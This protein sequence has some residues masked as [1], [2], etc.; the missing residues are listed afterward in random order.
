MNQI[1]TFVVNILEKYSSF[2]RFAIVGCINTL[3]YYL[4][5]I[6]F[7]FVG[8]PYIF[9]HSAAFGISMIGSFYLNCYYTYKVKPTWK[10]FIQ[11]PMTYVVN[12]SV[13]TLSLF[14]IVDLLHLNAFIA[15]IISMLLP[16]PFTFLVSKW[17]L[18]K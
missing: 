5:Y 16:I 4:L 7:M 10:K 3:N 1:C 13:S 15:P 12:Y 18:V 11:F 6:L 9:S 14:V 17:I 8:L 2:I